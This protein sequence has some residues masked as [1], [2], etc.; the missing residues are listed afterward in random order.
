MI[1]IEDLVAIIGLCLTAIKLGFLL[2][3]NDTKK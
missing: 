3:K 1:S 2:G